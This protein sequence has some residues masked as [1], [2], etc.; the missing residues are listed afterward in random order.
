[1]FNTLASNFSAFPCQGFRIISQH[2]NGDKRKIKGG[3][4]SLEVGD[5]TLKYQLNAV[6]GRQTPSRL[7]FNEPALSQLKARF[8]FLV[9]LSNL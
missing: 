5:P 7:A 6:E 2:E 9:S 1:M 8:K 4:N 3:L